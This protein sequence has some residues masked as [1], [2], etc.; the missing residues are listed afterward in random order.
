MRI[1]KSATLAAAVLTAAVLTSGTPTSASA[2]IA[3]LSITAINYNSYGADTVTNNT[4]YVEVKNVHA[5]DAVNVKDLLV[6]DAWA[7]GRDKTTGCNTFRLAAGVLPVAAGGNA[8]ELPAGAVLRLHMG[9]GTPA[10]DRW[11]IRHVYRAMPAVCGY[12]SNVFNNSGPKNN[13]FAEWDRVWVTLGSDVEFKGY[14]FSFG[15]VA[16]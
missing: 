2:E 10:I 5:T 11:G 13:R 12:N 9:A 3:N 15:Y 16:R 4:E 14:N 6:Q 7:R 1:N 8:D